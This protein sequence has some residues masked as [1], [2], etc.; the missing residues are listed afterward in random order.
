LG[1]NQRRLSRRFYRALPGTTAHEY[2]PAK[3]PSRSR[4]AHTLN[5]SS[6]E[7]RSGG[8]TTSGW[9]WRPAIDQ[10]GS[11]GETAR[12]DEA[13]STLAS[14]TSS[15]ALSRGM[16]APPYKRRRPSTSWPKGRVR[17]A[18]SASS[19]GRI[20]LPFG[21]SSSATGSAVTPAASA[22]RWKASSAIPRLDAQARGSVRLRP[23]D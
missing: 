22:P 20:S 4:A 5:H 8:P 14:D 1:S 9:H 16:P 23:D 3:T 2:L 7:S 6:T 19:Q 18:K 13:T 10:G 11:R 17:S 12:Q 21:C 15:R